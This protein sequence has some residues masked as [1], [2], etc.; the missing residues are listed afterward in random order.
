MNIQNQ[1]PLRRLASG[2]RLGFTLIELLVVISIISL[3]ISIL[4]PALA[5]AR[6]RATV[7][8]CANNMKQ[9]AIPFTS[10]NL[11]HK[12]WTP[13]PMSNWDSSS[14]DWSVGTSSQYNYSQ[15]SN[16]LV[17][18]SYIGSF[19]Q[20]G[21]PNRDEHKALS[22]FYCPED[23]DNYTNPYSNQPQV[24]LSYY[25]VYSV[26]GRRGVLG[27]AGYARW[28]NTERY[29][30]PSDLF[31]LVETNQLRNSLAVRNTNACYALK[32][33]ETWDASAPNPYFYNWNHNVKNVLHADM[34]VS[35][36][37]IKALLTGTDYPGGSATDKNWEIN[38]S[39]EAAD[40][41][42]RY[43]SGNW[44]AQ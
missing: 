26:F 9:Q 18:M 12:G 28:S 43:V 5:E 41:Y 15:Y 23:F 30:H 33:R 2:R 1:L 27:A 21:S 16:K 22:V 34:H 29:S 37:D 13:D 32:A 10:Y 14:G 36:R 39:A 20:S 42:F 38:D 44:V 25:P 8:K 3:L 40:N 7:I 31:L 11:D 6:E 4:L 35:S 17:L 24:T 19:R